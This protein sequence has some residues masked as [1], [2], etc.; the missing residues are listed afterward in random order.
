MFHEI[1]FFSLNISK[2]KISQKYPEMK[3]VQFNL[4]SFT[5]VASVTINTAACVLE[6]TIFTGSTIHARVTSTFIDVCQ[7]NAEFQ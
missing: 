6:Y 4:T 3:A 5:I 7:H 1:F 2:K